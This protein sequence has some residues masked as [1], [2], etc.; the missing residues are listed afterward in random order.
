MDLSFVDFINLHYAQD[1]HHHDENDDRLPFKT[2]DHFVNSNIVF[3]L[4]SS[5]SEIVLR[6]EFET[7]REFSIPKGNFISNSNPSMIWQPPKFS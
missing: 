3:V 1:S 5:F 6:T 2:Q 4:D 7:E